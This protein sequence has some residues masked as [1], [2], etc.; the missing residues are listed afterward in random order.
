[1]VPS[2]LLLHHCISS[3]N[4]PRERIITSEKKSPISNLVSTSL[5]TN[6]K[7]HENKGL[8]ES[9]EEIKKAVDDVTNTNNNLRNNIEE[10]K[11]KTMRN[12]AEK[13]EK[14]I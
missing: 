4:K 5:K 6:T 1:M 7:K 11:K 3:F 14:E 2:Q 8:V 10:A 9:L 12:L 13:S